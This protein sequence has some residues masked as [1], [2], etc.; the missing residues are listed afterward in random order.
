[1]RSGLR[2]EKSVRAALDKLLNSGTDNFT[3]VDV[4]DR[5]EFAAGHIP[6]AINIPLASFAAKSTVLDKK[7]RIIVYC[8]SGGRS[9]DA[10]R[11]LMKLG[12]KNIDQAI[13]AD[14]KAAGLPVS[15]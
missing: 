6:A 1:M 7:K 15:R 10:Y 12:Y 13:F 3:V 2:P 9:Y 14:W 8:N 4:R 11:K 5:D